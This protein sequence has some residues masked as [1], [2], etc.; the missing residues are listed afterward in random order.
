M[1]LMCQKKY[2]EETRVRKKQYYLI[3][4]KIFTPYM[5]GY[6]IWLLQC[7]FILIYFVTIMG[8]FNII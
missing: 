7:T 2:Y 1:T 4:R 8:F 6:V 5:I 3:I